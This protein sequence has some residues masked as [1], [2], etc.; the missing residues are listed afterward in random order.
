MECHKSIDSKRFILLL[1]LAVQNEYENKSKSG[2]ESA[3]DVYG[4]MKTAF[5]PRGQVQQEA[6]LCVLQSVSLNASL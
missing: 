6:Q 5:L 3:D 4:S 1:L 2:V